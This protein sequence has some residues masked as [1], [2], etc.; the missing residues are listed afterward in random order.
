[1]KERHLNDI[2]MKA[3]SLGA[4]ECTRRTMDTDDFTP[5]AFIHRKINRND[6]S[7]ISCYFSRQHILSNAGY[8]EYIK[9]AIDRP[10]VVLTFSVMKY[11]H[12][13]IILFAGDHA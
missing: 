4:Q 10:S 13:K 9:V 3:L 1:M 11:K 7:F 8:F 6:F 2:N 12:N 5:S